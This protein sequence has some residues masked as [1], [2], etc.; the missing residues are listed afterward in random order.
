MEKHDATNQIV[1]T[2]PANQSSQQ[3]QKRKHNSRCGGQMGMHTYF[4]GMLV[5]EHRETIPRHTS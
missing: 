5:A 2:M 4:T 3:C 1:A